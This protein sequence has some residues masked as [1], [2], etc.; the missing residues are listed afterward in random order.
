MTAALIGGAMA[1]TA[2]AQT[3]TAEQALENYRD[4]FVPVS[5]LDCPASENPHEIVVCGRSPGAPDPNRLPL[6]YQPLPGARDTADPLSG[7][8][9]LTSADPRSHLR[10]HHG[11]GGPPPLFPA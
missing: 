8:A 1:T 10:P 2:S 6:P 3:L 4:T 5:E 11:C 7:T 9:A